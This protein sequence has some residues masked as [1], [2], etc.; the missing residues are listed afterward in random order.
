MSLPR[1]SNNNYKLYYF[2]H[3]VVALAGPI[4]RKVFFNDPKLHIS[5]GYKI[6][7]GGVPDI[8]DVDVKVATENRS[9]GIKRLLLLIHKDRLAESEWNNRESQRIH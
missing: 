4:A 2:Q 7:M 8:R 3:R 1:P 6:L 5:E 9:V